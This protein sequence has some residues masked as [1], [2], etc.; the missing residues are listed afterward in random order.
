LSQIEP[1]NIEEALDDD[2]WIFA[3]QEELN[4]YE[5]SQMWTLIPRPKDK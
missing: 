2:G 3:L 5:S 1:K 4:Q